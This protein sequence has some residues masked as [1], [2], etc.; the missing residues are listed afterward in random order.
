[1]RKITIYQHFFTNA[2]CYKNGRKTIPKGIQ[3]HST[4]ATNSYLK[5][6]VGP[7]DGRLGE[8]KYNNTHN[9][10]GANVCASAYIGRLDDGTPAIYQALPWDMCCWLSASGPKGNANFLG[11]IGFEICEDNRKNKDYFDQVVMGLSVN[12]VA[13]LCKKFNIPINKV[14]DHSELYKAGIASN[15]GDI[16][17]WLKNFG[18]NMNDYRAAV[19]AAMKEGVQATY[20]KN[21]VIIDIDG[22]KEQEEKP[23]PV[24]YTAIVTA[25]SG[26]T[27]NFRK[28]PS[29]TSDIII[30]IPIGEKVEVLEETN[31]DWDKV[32]FGGQTGYIMREFL[33]PENSNKDEERKKQLKELKALL[34]E[35]ISKI[36]QILN[37]YQE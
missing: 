3:V 16:T 25:K 37:S 18:L 12:L 1:M 34:N 32:S 4:G 17:W 36:D 20:I 11:Y 26:K 9:R 23:M 5:R 33:L 35:A 14:Q 10:P 31:N 19:Q 6:Y 13:Y 2:D 29:T 21:N 7:N 24:L 8:N 15:H 22:D 27:V 30:K 28:K